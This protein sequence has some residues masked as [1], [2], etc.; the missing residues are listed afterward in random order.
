MLNTI[1]ETQPNAYGFGH[2]WYLNVETTEGIKNFRL[3]Q[4]VKVCSRM[5]GMTPKQVCDE[6]GSN[7]LRNEETRKN[8]GQFILNTLGICF[9]DEINNLQPWELSVD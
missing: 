1:I 4:D 8:L 9:E 5:L 3:G 6:I 7:D 2:D